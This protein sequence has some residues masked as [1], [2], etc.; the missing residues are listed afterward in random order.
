[1]HVDLARRALPKRAGTLLR[2]SALREALGAGIDVHFHTSARQSGA[3]FRARFEN[4]IEEIARLGYDEIVAVGRDCPALCAADVGQA[5]AEL[6]ERTLVLGPD[7][8]GG[9]YLIAFRTRD[10]E[11]LRDVRWKRNTDCRQLQDRCAPG[12]VFLLPVKHDVDNWAD[13]EV[14]A[15]SG[16]VLAGI[17]GSLVAMAGLAGSSIRYFVSS[18]W[19]AT[20]I[21][22]QIPPPAFAA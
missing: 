1:M 19:R 17:A 5:F 10:R 20:R 8:R 13:L 11:L 18:A 6:S 22:Q 14:F 7:H 3:G 16:H 9:C 21:R 4:A 15:R 2:G 12:A